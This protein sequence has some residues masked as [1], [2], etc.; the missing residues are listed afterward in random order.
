[1]KVKIRI[2][3]LAK[4]DIFEIQGCVCKVRRIGEREV[5]FTHFGEAYSPC[6]YTRAK[7]SM[8][9][10]WKITA[11][12]REMEKETKIERPAAIYSN[13]SYWDKAI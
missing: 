1:M 3:E 8:Q 12:I 6:R 4:G 7:N 2:R 5:I 11:E 9:F 10:V 13:A